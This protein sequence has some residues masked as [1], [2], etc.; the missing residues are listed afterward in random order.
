MDY[1]Y[2]S[3]FLGNIFNNNKYI[4]NIFLKKDDDDD[5]KFQSNFSHF[6]VV[7]VHQSKTYPCVN[8]AP[9][10]L[11]TNINKYIQ[12]QNLKDTDLK[13]TLSLQL[14]LIFFFFFFFLISATQ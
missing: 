5:E 3:T 2:T 7:T 1:K 6:K 11:P 4:N 13:S 9:I 14:L 10:H 8:K 12:Q